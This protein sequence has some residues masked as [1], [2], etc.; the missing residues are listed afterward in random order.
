MKRCS[1]ALEARDEPSTTTARSEHDQAKHHAAA[2][3]EHSELAQKHSETA[4]TQ[5]LK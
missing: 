1:V 4:H 2:A 5:S 3:K